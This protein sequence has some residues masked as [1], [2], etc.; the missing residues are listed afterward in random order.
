M[1]SNILWKKFKSMWIPVKSGTV[2]STIIDIKFSPLTTTDYKYA[3]LEN[4]GQNIYLEIYLNVV[5][6]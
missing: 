5:D 6:I 4:T 3:V 2:F 1:G